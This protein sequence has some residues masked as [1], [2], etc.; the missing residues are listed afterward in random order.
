MSI[1]MEN[2][3]LFCPFTGI[4]TSYKIVDPDYLMYQ[5]PIDDRKYSFLIKESLNIESLDFYQKNRHIYM[6]LVL[7]K[8]WPNKS[9]IIIDSETNLREILNDNNV[10]LTP[11]EKL[12]Y[13]F[14]HVYNKQ[15]Y[16]G[17][18]FSDYHVF[19][20]KRPE[21]L[22]LRTVAE[23]DFYIGALEENKLIKPKSCIRKLIWRS[24]D[25]QI[26]K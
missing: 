10:P 5:V 23:Q 7:N 3:Q 1:I 14:L 12:E 21:Y 17:Q 26:F 25:F 6:G 11:S 15:E 20:N 8:K 18:V 4:K 9:E 24:N 2:N 13:I 22:Y 19:E 16:E